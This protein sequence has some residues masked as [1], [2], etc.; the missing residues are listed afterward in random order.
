MCNLHQSS[1]CQVCLLNII[2]FLFVSHYPTT[3]MGV[4]GNVQKKYLPEEEGR[5]GGE[6]NTQGAHGGRGSNPG[7]TVC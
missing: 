6:K 5:E 7:P 4:V 3:F 2:C 1:K